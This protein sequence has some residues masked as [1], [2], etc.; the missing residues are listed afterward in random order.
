ML[1][2]EVDENQHK[3]HIKSDEN[4]RHDELVMD[5]SGQYIFIKYNPDK[6]IDKCNTS[7]NP[8]FQRRTDLL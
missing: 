3:Y 2:L 6:V 5:F 7:K 4:N 8:F 1:C